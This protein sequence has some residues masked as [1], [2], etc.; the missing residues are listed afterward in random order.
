MVLCKGLCPTY[1]LGYVVYQPGGST[2]GPFTPIAG[3]AVGSQDLSPEASEWVTSGMAHGRHI[4]E[5]MLW[6]FCFWVVTFGTRPKISTLSR[7]IC[8]TAAR[9]VSGFMCSQHSQSVCVWAAIAGCTV[10]PK[11]GYAL[12]YRGNSCMNLMAGPTLVLVCGSRVCR[13]ST[14]GGILV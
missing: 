12:N 3:G 4:P 8:I 5:L 11:S 10:W 2:Q 7:N 14:T 6:F 13:R 1:L 9:R